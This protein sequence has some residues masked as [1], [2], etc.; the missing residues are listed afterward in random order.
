MN[1]DHKLDK[2]ELVE[3]ENGYRVFL[4][5]N[6]TQSKNEQGNDIWSADEV[7]L[8]LPKYGNMLKFVTDNF[9]ELYSRNQI[10]KPTIEER[11]NALE[12]EIFGDTK[13]SLVEK[14][15]HRYLIGKITLQDVKNKLD[16][17]KITL[18]EFKDIKKI[19]KV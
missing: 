12:E 10:K 13:K 11:L 16:S 14:L 2:I 6:I 19:E 3:L 4:R 15:T 9:A 17:G 1:S 8:E 7:I 5:K 18:N